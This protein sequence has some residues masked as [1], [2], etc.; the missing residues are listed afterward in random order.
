[1][2]LSYLF[3]EQ[4]SDAFVN[5]FSTQLSVLRNAERELVEYAERFVT[6]ASSNVNDL[7]DVQVLDTSIPKSAVYGSMSE[8]SSSRCT[9]KEQN[10]QVYSSSVDDDHYVMHAIKVKRRGGSTKGAHVK[11]TAPVVIQHG[12]CNAGI[13]FY[14]NL[15]GLSEKLHSGEVYALDML[16]WG[17]SS[18]PK[19]LVDENFEETGNDKLTRKQREMNE[20]RSAEHFFTESLEQWRKAQGIEKMT[21]AG[22]S[23]GGYLSV[24]YAEKYP[25]RVE[26][27]ILVSP[28]GVPH[29]DEKE[30]KEK[31]SKI[32]L[33][34]R[35]MFG[36]FR[37]LWRAGITP[38]SF[39]RTVM[40]EYRGKNFVNS[41]VDKRLPAIDVED[42][43]VAL[44]DYMYVNNILPGSGEYVLNYVLRPGAN[45]RDALV[46]RI[47][48]LKVS[49]VSF[50]YGKS[51]WMDIEGGLE[52]QQKSENIL[53]EG[54]EAPEIDV[55]RVGQAGH[56]LMLENWFEFNTGFLKSAGGDVADNYPQPER[57]H[58]STY[59]HER[60]LF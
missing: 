45:A 54:K 18:R 40:S 34:Y 53:K 43:K 5:P 7:F 24:A 13:F 39:M 17:L 49:K 21:L 51:D 15:F 60:R 48:H 32:P 11:N 36:T 4:K 30:E 2:V 9:K 59:E 42:E 58:H 10:C 3:G 12:Y 19:F 23:M 41:Y 33:T 47:P 25:H 8:K 52:V 56:L 29:V 31:W 55:Y 35:I 44:A 14:R 22:H 37:G 1:M 16:G 6:S 57:I 50:L 46:H 28:A 20:V 26:R 27:L 38:G